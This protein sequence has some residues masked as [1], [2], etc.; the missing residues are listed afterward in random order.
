MDL[1][2]G[3]LCHGVVILTQPDQYMARI[4]VD[5]VHEL[6]LLASLL[7]VI[8][9]YAD[10]VDPEAPFLIWLPKPPQKIME[11]GSEFKVCIV[12]DDIVASVRRAPTVRN[13]LVLCLVLF[14]R[15]DVKEFKLA[16]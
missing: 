7:L 13:C 12:A 4:L 1:L 3:G 8:L 14:R 2:E 9:V 11:A 16:L 5:S 15:V 10:L 6:D